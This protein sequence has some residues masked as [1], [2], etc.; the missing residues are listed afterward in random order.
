[1]FRRSWATLVLMHVHSISSSWDRRRR[2]SST[3]KHP[4]QLSAPVLREMRAITRHEL[5]RRWMRKWLAWEGKSRPRRRLRWRRDGEKSGISRGNLLTHS[6]DFIS[7]EGETRSHSH[8]ALREL[9][10][11]LFVILSC[12]LARSLA[13]SRSVGGW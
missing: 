3:S 2:R 5:D 10:K 7:S 8:S 4:A 1:M 12:S 13:R 9:E 11:Q 6:L